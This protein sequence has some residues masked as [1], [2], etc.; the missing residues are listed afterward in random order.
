MYRNLK[1]FF[2][3]VTL[4]LSNTVNAQDKK[5]ISLIE[6]M[7]LSLRNHPQL[8]ISRSAVAINDQQEKVAGLQK[9]PAL[10][11]SGSAFYMG[12]VFTLDKDFK[13]KSDI[14]IPN[15]GNSFALQAGQLLFKGGLIKKSIELANL[16]TQL[17]E[18]DLKKDIQNIKFLV[19]SNYLDLIRID[20]QIR[21]LENNKTLARERLKNVGKFYEQDMVTRNEVIRA[22]LAI[23]NLDQALLTANNNR[24][25]VNYQIN[26]ALGLP[27]GTRL[28]PTDKSAIE[29][30]HY[31]LD[32]YYQLSASQNPILKA[33]EKNIELAEKNIALTKTEFYPGLSAVGG[34]NMQRP[35][36]NSF[37]AR[38]IYLNAWQ[39]GVSLSYNID[40]LY[41]TRQRVKTG[42][43]LKKQAGEA[44]FLTQQNLSTA[45]YAG[46]VKYHEAI[47]Q[48]IIAKEAKRLA[49]ENYKIID[50]KYLNQLAVQ[51]EMTDAQN[52][53]LQADIDYEN[54]LINIRFQYYNLIK[55][56]GTL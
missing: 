23:Q 30:E 19:V 15:F 14:D 50:S 38:D 13:D 3:V 47:A 18:L 10:T 2:Y 33:G 5:Y 7:D 44:L 56:T 46:F 1:S 52:Q 8:A 53:K 40:N 26:I 51:A 37:P 35:L 55:A 49:D 39:V 36:M 17:S 28:E 12:D 22:E 27:E 54:A 16:R 43:L 31:P 41:K 48:E 29:N 9:I 42:E 32:Y 20:N 24:S 34:Y 45:I 6:V 11:F 25:I 21:V 4:F